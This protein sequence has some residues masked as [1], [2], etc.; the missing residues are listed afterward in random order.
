MMKYKGYIGQAQYDDEAEIFHGEVVNTRDVITFQS[1]DAK[2][3]KK[4]MAESIDFYLDHCEKI[5][6]SP[7]KP[8][9][10]EFLIR[11]TPEHHGLF[12]AAAKASGLS[13]NKWADQT[14]EAQARKI[15]A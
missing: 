15:I 9:P 2:A 1:D 6:K 4:E 14:L 8:Y 7:A 3:L 11:T 12:S 5:G 10:G 13:L